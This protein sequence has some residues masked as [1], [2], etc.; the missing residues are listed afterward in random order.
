M[1]LALSGCV[2]ATTTTYVVPSQLTTLY[3]KTPAA[4]TNIVTGPDGRVVCAHGTVSITAA[5]PDVDDG[6]QTV[7]V[8]EWPEPG[9]LGGDIVL[10]IDRVTEGS[11]WSYTAVL[12]ELDGKPVGKPGGLPLLGA[13]TSKLTIRVGVGDAVPAPDTLALC[14]PDALG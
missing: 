5:G 2:S 6:G 11:I 9:Q 12:G 4:P 14:R 8:L 1:A 13:R 10:G 3:G 7:F